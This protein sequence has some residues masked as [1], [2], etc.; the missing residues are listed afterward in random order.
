MICRQFSVHDQQVLRAFRNEGDLYRGIREVI[1]ERH[2]GPRLEAGRPRPIPPALQHQAKAEVRGVYV[3]VMNRR[4]KYKDVLDVL[5][6]M[7]Q[8]NVRQDRRHRIAAA[9]K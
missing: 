1:Q 8:A 5:V 6:R 7:V 3:T 9:L 2:Y 4:S